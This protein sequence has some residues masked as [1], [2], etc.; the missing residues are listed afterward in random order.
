MSE[1][2]ARTRVM[3]EKIAKL[4]EEI[5]LE[6]EDACLHDKSR[7]ERGADSDGPYEFCRDCGKDLV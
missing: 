7:R 6:M 4:V 1:R 5:R 3:L 2:I